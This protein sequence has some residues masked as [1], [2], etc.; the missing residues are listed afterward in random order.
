MSGLD[1][2]WRDGY[3]YAK[4]GIMLNDFYQTGFA[5]LD[6]FREHQPR[7]NTDSLMAT[8]DTMNKSGKGKIYFASQGTDQ[9]WLMKREMLSPRY[10][11]CFSKL[12]TVK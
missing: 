1:I 3:R 10:T 8:L 11:T 7:A 6:M 2:I 12:L 5:Q 4:A 9:H